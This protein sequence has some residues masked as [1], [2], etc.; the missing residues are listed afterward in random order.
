[1]HWVQLWVD[2][3]LLPPNSCNE[4]EDILMNTLVLRRFKGALVL[5]LPD[6]FVA[7][8][9]LKTGSVVECIRVGQDMLIVRPGRNKLSLEQLLADTPEDSRV[10]GW[11]S[12]G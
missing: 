4:P 11:E 7:Q 2:L 5:S 10:K 6:E 12:L 9:H 3:P 8:N 1:L